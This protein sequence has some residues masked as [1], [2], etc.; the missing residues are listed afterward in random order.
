MADKPLIT[1]ESFITITQPADMVSDETRFAVASHTAKA[2]R[3]K[4]RKAVEFEP[5]RTIHKF[6]AWKAHSEPTSRRKLPKDA[7]NREQSSVAVVPYKSPQDHPA[8]ILSQARG[9]PFARYAVSDIPGLVGEVVDHAVRLFW[10][11]LTPSKAPNV[12]NPV[13]DAYMES[14]RSSPLAFYAYMVASAENY[15]LLSGPNMKTKAFTKLCLAYR[16]EMIKLV[17][18][19]IE[20]MTG[21]PSD[22]LLGAIIVLAG[23]SAGFINQARG[24]FLKVAKPSR[25]HSPLRTAQFLHVYSTNPFPSAHSEALVRLVIMKGGCSQIQSVGVASVVALC[26]LVIASQTNSRLYV[27]PMSPPT[28][29]AVQD[30]SHLLTKS[31]IKWDSPYAVWSQLPLRPSVRPELLQTVR[32]MLA[33]NT[34]LDCYLSKYGPSM[35]FADIVNARNDAQYLLLSLLPTTEVDDE[36]HSISETFSDHIYDIARIALRI[37]SNLI[38]FPM[39][40]SGGTSRILAGALREAIMESERANPW[41]LFPDTCK[42]MMLWALV[43]GGI[44]VDDG[45]TDANA[46]RTWF[47]EQLADVMSFI[48]VLSWHQVEECLAAFMW[49]D[50]ILNPTA[51]ELWADARRT[52]DQDL[53]ALEMEGLALRPREGL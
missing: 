15:E 16:V 38:L 35:V 13:N 21:P 23:N 8:N 36:T 46:E 51:V 11:G 48:D 30:L 14:I 9:D 4:R 29:A 33:A 39:N 27:L 2:R 53:E 3:R 17:N 49:L 10:P 22:E 18:Q 7:E 6:L 40:P 50:I 45:V 20:E 25:F 34:A 31:G 32:A 37:Y 19:E 12:V 43:L 42:R 1:P 28:F 44:Q 52:R 26:D 24:S 5:G 47:V 41:Q